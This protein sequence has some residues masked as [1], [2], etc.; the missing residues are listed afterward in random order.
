MRITQDHWLTPVRRR[1][2]PNS[3]ARPDP[4]AIE[5]VVVHGIS[6]PPGR[7][8]GRFVEDLFLNRIDLTAHP[9]FASLDG[10]R[11]SSHLFVSR[12]GRV[13]QFVPFDRRA[14][15]A[16]TSAWRG[17]P[18]C[19]DFAIGIELEGCDDRPYTASQYRRLRVLLAAL[20]ARYPRL[21]A[22][23][24][25]GHFEIAPQRKTDPGPRFDWPRALVG[26]T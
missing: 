19:N 9:T 24:V 18:G 17:R 4:A 20:L 13:A 22:D 5:L 3:D 26:A 25:V 14:W 1:E 6:L 21:A 15:H 10:V 12:R 8:G 11:V 2:S 23:A 16:G 7:F